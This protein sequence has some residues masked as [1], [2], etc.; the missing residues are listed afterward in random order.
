MPPP[1]S[2]ESRTAIQIWNVLGGLE[3]AGLPV[4]A[5]MYGVD[6]PAGLI[7]RLVLIRDTLAEKEDE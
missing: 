4:V 6:D 5:E 1:I 7:E 3:W 2:H